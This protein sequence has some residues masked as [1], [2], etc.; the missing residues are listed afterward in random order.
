MTFNFPILSLITFLPLIGALVVFAINQFCKASELLQKRVAFAFSMV[1]FAVSLVMMHGFD[2]A[3]TSLQFVERLQWIHGYEIFYYL[4]VDG[5]SLFMVMLTTLLTPI[6]IISSWNSI[7][8]R[9]T[10][11]LMLF[12]A[13]ETF[14]LGSFLAMDF[15]LF[16]IFFEAVLIPMYLIIGIWGGANRI[17]AAYKFFLYTL[18]GSVLLLLAIVYIYYQ[19]GTTDIVLLSSVLPGFSLNIQKWLWLAFFASFAVKI[20]MFPVHTWLP[21]AHVQAP[22]AGSVILAGVLLKLG[23]YGFLRFSLPMLPTASAYFADFVLILSSIAVVYT[24][25]VAL[26][27]EDMKKLIAYSSIAHMAFVTGGIFALNQQAIEGAIFQMISHGL[28]SAALFLAVGVLYDRMHTKE[29][30]FY[31]GVAGKMPKFALQLMIFTMASVGLPITSGF[32]GEF[33]VLLGV[34]EYS[35]LFSALLALG[36]VLGAAYMLWL[37]ARVMFGKIKNEKLKALKDLTPFE[38]ASFWPLALL[39]FMIGIYPNFVLSD[40]NAVIAKLVEHIHNPDFAKA[41]TMELPQSYE[42][43]IDLE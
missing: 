36:M 2:G 10:E 16:Y 39:V 21:D 9:V 27:Q 19:T 43:I 35:K 22:T 38:K 31:G 7:N 18:A 42:I 23:G 13:M 15:L 1:V 8:S 33:M 3:S 6:C 25:L 37:Y 24:S 20:P 5:I 40:L 11:F 41:A 12:L 4:G 28:V 26:M 17:Y 32:V 29:I 14:V 34:Y 30:A